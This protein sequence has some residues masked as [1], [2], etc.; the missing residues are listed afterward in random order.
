MISFDHVKLN[1][2]SKVIGNFLFGKVFLFAII[3]GVFL[4]EP[5]RAKSFTVEEKYKAQKKLLQL[6]TSVDNEDYLR[7]RLILGSFQKDFSD[8]NCYEMH[9]KRIDELAK[10]IRKE[11]KSIK[12]ED[13]I[14]YLF[15]PP[16]LK[17]NLWKEDMAR[18]ETLIS[19]NK[20][21]IGITVL[22]V[23]F[24]NEDIEQPSV[25]ADWNSSNGLNLYVGYGGYSCVDTFQSGKAAFI[26]SQ[27]WRCDPN[28]KNVSTTGDII[29][30]GV[31]HY[32]TKLKIKVQRGKAIAF[33]EVIVRSI[34]KE[35]C[36]NLMVKV[37][38]EEGL[39]LAGGAAR[40]SPYG[41][42]SGKTE[43]VKDGSCLFSS[44]G[45]GSYSIGI[46]SNDIFN[47]PSRSAEVVSGQTTEVTINAYRHRTIE[48]DWRFRDVNEPNNWLSGR[49][50]MKT[51]ESWQPDE[52]WPDVHYPV[53][54]FGDWVENTCNIRSSNGN[55]WPIQ[56]NESF[57][58]TEF[59][60]NFSSSY[61]D[62]YPIKE[63]DVFAWRRDD[64]KERV[65]EALIHI[66][67]I[68]PVKIPDINTNPH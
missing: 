34:P 65:L 2:F 47:G 54:A 26:G 37:E 22:R 13:K 63:G 6:Q 66:T 33:G 14:E 39:K 62:S 17:T 45:P 60:L 51:K 56:T 59:P 67:K 50:I 11:T 16:R 10:K 12:F 49:K 35:F 30:G 5:C 25:K 44:V 36:G 48:F 61:S 27:F 38:A 23:I 57:E 43:P 42:Y 4:T 64:R 41:F 52:E 68:T 58:K 46:L 3:A 55:I 31:Y 32:P 18:A 40:L 9:S 28:D 24:E 21:V 19:Q 7:A 8:T 53:I 1:G 20:G 15:V 29:I